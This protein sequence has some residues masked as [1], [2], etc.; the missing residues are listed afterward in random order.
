MLLF[1]RGRNMNINVNEF[2]SSLTERLSFFAIDM[3]VQAVL[4][5]VHKPILTEIRP[6][7][8]EFYEHIWSFEAT[9]EI[10]RNK[11]RI[12]ILKDKQI[13]HWKVLLSGVFGSEYMKKAKIIGDVHHRIGLKPNWY[14]GGYTFILS[15]IGTIIE[16]VLPQDMHQL[17]YSAISKAL[18]LD[19]EVA[20]T[21]YLEAADEEKA[22]SLNNLATGIE[23]QI[24]GSVGAIVDQTKSLQSSF[25]ALSTTMGNLDKSIKS[26]SENSQNAND[27]MESVASATEELNASVREIER[28]ASSSQATSD[29][30][31]EEA[32]RASDVVSGLSNTADQIGN[33]VQLISDI[34]SQTN[35]L[36]LNATIEAARAG[37]A[38]KGFAVVASEVKSLANETAQATASISNQ[39]GEIQEAAKNAVKAIQDIGSVIDDMKAN[40]TAIVNAVV[41][42][43]LATSQ[44]SANIQDA[45]TGSQQVSTQL[46]GMVGEVADAENVAKTIRTSSDVAEQTAADLEKR[47]GQFVDELKVEAG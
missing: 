17:A 2:D 26:V 29:Q 30:A 8:D 6:L 43:S 22:V 9:R 16:R 20:I 35:L 45:A 13:E 31:V 1:N 7:L 47:V 25:S 10:I 32:Q 42:Q 33:V 38:G 19:L 41:E 12:E 14:I 34:A 36:A 24:Q 4:A 21:V 3:S 39:I 40:S 44:I 27:N 15:R 18:M 37:D 46:E 5:D 23:A 11:D 28:Q